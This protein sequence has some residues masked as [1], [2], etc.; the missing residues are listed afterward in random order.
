MEE[1]ETKP[2]RQAVRVEHIRVDTLSKMPVARRAQVCHWEA[3][4]VV[5]THDGAAGRSDSE[6]TRP[7]PP[8]QTAAGKKAAR[9]LPY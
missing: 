3:A 1:D 7:G 5:D 8:R 2:A 6:S 9:R 4:E